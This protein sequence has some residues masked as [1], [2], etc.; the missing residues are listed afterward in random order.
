MPHP[1]SPYLALP[2]VDF[3]LSARATKVD[4]FESKS[5]AKAY[6]LECAETISELA[7][8][9][10]A[11][12]GERSAPKVLIVLQGMDTSGKDSTTKAMFRRTPPLNV[13][14]APFK[15]PTKPELARDYL[16]RVHQVV[17]RKGEIVIF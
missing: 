4:V 8:K 1:A 6:A 10:Y 7:Q 13:R 5:E 12:A 9:L 15:A 16:W 3:D 14:I 17:P 11:N 2:G